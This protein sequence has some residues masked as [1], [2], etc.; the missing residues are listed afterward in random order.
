MF[1]SQLKDVWENAPHANEVLHHE[2]VESFSGVGHVHLSFAI[3]EV[4]LEWY[5]PQS[6]RVTFAADLL[7]DVREGGCMVQVEAT[8]R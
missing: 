6:H 1:S 7:H 8:Q 2:F 5:K 4:C 3:S